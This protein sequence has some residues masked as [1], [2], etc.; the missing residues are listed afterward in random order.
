MV[1][2]LLLFSRGVNAPNSNKLSLV[3]GWLRFNQAE[4][5][6]DSFI[7]SSLDLRLGLDSFNIEPN[8]SLS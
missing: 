3:Q 8:T 7:I 4:L 5:E 6:L 1:L 2:C